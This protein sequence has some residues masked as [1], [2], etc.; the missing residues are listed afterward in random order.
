MDNSFKQEL[1]QR[2]FSALAGS[3]R[4]LLKWATGCGKSKMTIDLINAVV[5]TFERHPVRVLFVVAERAHIGN[6]QD[7]MLKWHLNIDR[8]ATEVVCYASL[9]KIQDNS[10]DILVFDEAHHMFSE[11]RF[12]CVQ[13]LCEN[14]SLNA[15]VFLLSATIPSGRVDMVEEIFGKF[16]VSTVTLKDA[17]RND[18]LPDPRIYVVEMMLDNSK[19]YQEIKI[20]NNPNA[21]VIK[22]EDRKKYIY[23][24][25][26]CII[27]CTEFQKYSYLTD[28]LEYWKGR[29]QL[30]YSEFMHNKFVNYG[31][32]RKRF[33]GEAKTFALRRLLS[34][35]PE[36][37][38]YVCFCASVAQAESLCAKDT[39]SSNKTPAKNQAII[40]AFNDKKTNRIFAVGMI[41][42]GMNLTDTNLGIIGQ[43]DGKER[44][45]I[46]KFGRVMRADSP[47]VCIFYYKG[48]QDETYLNNA[49]ENIDAKYIRRININ[50]LNNIRL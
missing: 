38:R 25:T 21:P 42:E 40:E 44:L 10:Y 7:E 9:G 50:Q 12:A 20:G 34:L 45:F 48:T 16:S 30:S 27:P 28:S 37:R 46:Q 4:V 11:K 36:D 49:L 32:Q 13:S 18:I 31:S 47:V 22:W 39:I 35:I 5:P 6:W 43:L 14:M 2:E 29:Y 26:P 15:C 1:Q 24:H 33:L 41:T 19:R 17:I 8:I 23:S 3:R